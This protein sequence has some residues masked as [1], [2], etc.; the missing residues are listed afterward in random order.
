MK[1]RQNQPQSASDLAAVMAERRGDTTAMENIKKMELP[2]N[3][4]NAKAQVHFMA[5]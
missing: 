5:E 1:K 3:A 2:K 4:T